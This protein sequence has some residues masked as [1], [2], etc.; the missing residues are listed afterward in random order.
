MYIAKTYPEIQSINEHNQYLQNNIDLIKELY[1][2][3]IKDCLM[4][5]SD[6]ECLKIGAKYHDI[7]K[8][9][10]NMQAKLYKIG[11]KY[12]SSLTIP[13]YLLNPANHYVENVPHGLISAVM[14]PYDNY[15]VFDD[16]DSRII[17]ALAVG[18]HHERDWINNKDISQ[19]K[20]SIEDCYQ[21][22]IFPFIDEIEGDTDIVIAREID[23]FILG[24]LARR[25]TMSRLY[26]N[27]ESSTEDRDFFFRYVL[28]KGLLMKIDHSASAMIDVEDRYEG[29]GKY[30]A[31]F[32][33]RKYKINELQSYTNARKDKNIILIAQ[34]GMGKTEAALYWLGEDKGFFTLPF[35]VSTNA[36]YDRIRNEMG[37]ESIGLLHSSSRDYL[38][39]NVASYQAIFDKS[40]LLSYKLTMTTIDQILKFPYMYRGF[41]KELATLAYSKVIIDEIQS[42]DPKIVAMLIKALEMIYLIGGK[43]MIMT[44]TLPPIYLNKIKERGIIP[45][46][47]IEIPSKPFIEPSLNSRH[48]I[49]I[50]DDCILENSKNIINQ[51]KNNQVL[52]I[53]NTIKRAIELYFKLKMESNGDVNIYLLHTM[54]KKKHRR[55]LEKFIREFNEEKNRSTLKGIWVTTQLVEASLDV[56]FDYEHTE[57]STLDSQF[58]R[59]GRCFRKRTTIPASPN[60]FVYTKDI[61]G[62]RTDKMKNEI[63]YEK[64]L[65]DKSVELLSQYDEEVLTEEN[66]MTLIEELYS[67]DC[68]KDT[69]F[70]MQLEDSLYKFDNMIEVFSNNKKDVQEMLREI[71]TTFVIDYETYVI[72]QNDIEE[73]KVLVKTSRPNRQRIKELKTK[74]EN[75]L[76]PVNSKALKKDKIIE[77]EGIDGFFKVIKPEYK[78]SE[79]YGLDIYNHHE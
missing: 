47:E 78:Y 2:S 60:I 66:K 63:I 22:T 30:V 9:T 51:G 44:A 55:Y 42:Y 5:D 13:K 34:T 41:E 49:K 21:K 71:E 18:Y 40:T 64:Y 35:R 16:K 25:G 15:K 52:V 28:I 76:I 65:V 38:E 11:S 77:G 29:V 10:P 58:Q 20:T 56:D 43:F 72:L 61:S 26:F 12:S 37:Y 19:I 36:L 57:A 75:E 79:V 3:R 48:R 62:V 68:L 59:Y 39:E 46:D 6:W 50:E 7:G 27:N 45:L 32:I 33:S 69:D 67:E 1:Q 54:F 74:I 14:I 24:R 53:V 8:V 17:T 4:R 31:D 73:Y 23:A 70:L